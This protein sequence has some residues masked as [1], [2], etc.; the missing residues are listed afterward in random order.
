MIV[1]VPEDTAFAIPCESMVATLLVEELQATVLVMP[2]VDPSLNVPVAVNCCDAPGAIDALGG[3]IA[4]ETRVALVIVSDA[5]PTCPAKTAEIVTLPGCTPVASPK[6]PCAL[7][8]VAIEDADDV[9]VAAA[10]RF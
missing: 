6:L 1:V 2:A 9:H 7:L 3:V 10:V 8:T 5:V 4:I